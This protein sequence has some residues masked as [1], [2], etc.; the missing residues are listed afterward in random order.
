MLEVMLPTLAVVP[1]PVPVQ[2]PVQVQPPVVTLPLVAEVNQARA[3]QAPVAVLVGQV[4]DL[5]IHHVA[6]TVPKQVDS[7]AMEVEE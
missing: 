2:A 1:Q 7:T 3:V 6:V 5:V 4:Q